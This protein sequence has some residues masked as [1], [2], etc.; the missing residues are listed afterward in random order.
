M[1]DIKNYTDKIRNKKVTRGEIIRDSVIDAL[2]AMGR[3]GVDAQ[4]LRGQ[5]FSYFCSY[6]D[7][8]KAFITGKI[9]GKEVFDKEPTPGSNKTVSS[10]GLYKVHKDLN[11]KV[12]DILGIKED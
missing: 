10:G 2:K 1:A 7:F 6:K 8:I 9:A 5:K 11:D 3:N 12:N 4:S